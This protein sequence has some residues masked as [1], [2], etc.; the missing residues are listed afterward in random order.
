MNRNQAAPRRAD[1]GEEDVKGLE[2]SFIT[3]VY[4]H[5]DIVLNHLDLLK[6]AIEKN[7]GSLLKS[8]SIKRGE[9]EDEDEGEGE[10]E[11]ISF[12]TEIKDTHDKLEELNEE[13]NGFKAL[14]SEL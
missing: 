14:L 13:I 9:G 1:E 7:K 3:N 12:I 8:M 2:T 10:G 6:K 11:S 4:K 5:N